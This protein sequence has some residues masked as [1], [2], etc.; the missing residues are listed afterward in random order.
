[1]KCLPILGID[2]KYKNDSAI[3]DECKEKIYN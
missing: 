3:Q 1:L 2:Q